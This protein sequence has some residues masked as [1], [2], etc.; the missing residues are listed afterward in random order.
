MA[1]IFTLQV[2]CCQDDGPCIC[3]DEERVLRHYTYAPIDLQPMTP[4]QREWCI[5]EADSAA[6]G[7]WSRDDLVKLSDRELADAVLR[8]WKDYAVSQGMY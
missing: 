2:S 6:E 8:A 5:Q 3:G 1:N 7:A 4:E